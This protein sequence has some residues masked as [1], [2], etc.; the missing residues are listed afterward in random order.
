MRKKNLV[1]KNGN[2]G[3]SK[4][5]M[6][7]VLVGLLSACSIL[8][9]EEQVLAPPLVEPAKLEY[10]TAEVTKGEIIKRVKGTGSLVPLENQSLYYEKDG[11]RLKDI[12]VSE[13]EKVK[14]GQTLLEIETG[15]LAFDIQQAELDLQK[16]KLRL[17]QMQEQ[18]G[19][20]YSIEIAKLDV[21]SLELRLY[22][23]NKQLTESKII[24]PMNG[25]ITYVSELKQGEAVGAYQSIIQVADTS[26]LQI[27]YTALGAEDLAD[28][29][30][31]ME[32]T[33]TLKGSSVT[34]KVVQ[35]P[36]DVPFEIYE[37]DPNLYGKSLLINIEE[38]PKGAEVGSITDIEIITAKK[39]DTLI[40]PKNGL[41]SAMGRTYVQVL[42]ENTKREL[43]VEVGIV[44]ATEVEILRG[45]NEGDQVIL[46]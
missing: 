15:N 14:K 31:G 25:I 45:L 5:S 7:V 18:G 39:D 19:D 28:V 42:A 36:K 20:K 40:I 43:D 9:Q 37:R 27:L 41:R 29:K 11:G 22:Q 33:V 34:G 10:E 6:L 23:L 3:L 12:L 2:R 26:K 13:G 30:V 32:A 44:S 16:A 46:K 35:T 1:Y 17:Q 4:V 8:P 24:S 21:K 38:L